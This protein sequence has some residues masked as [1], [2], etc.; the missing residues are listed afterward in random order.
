MGDLCR[1]SLGRDHIP[2]GEAAGLW[3][4][5]WNHALVENQPPCLIA[6]IGAIHDHRQA[7]GHFSQLFK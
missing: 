6:F 3:R 5:Y 7:L 1:G 2:K 4:N